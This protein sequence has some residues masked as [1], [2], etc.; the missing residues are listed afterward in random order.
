MLLTS[1]GQSVNQFPFS[2]L[3]IAE[4]DSDLCLGLFEEKLGF[5]SLG[6]RFTCLEK[7]RSKCIYCPRNIVTSIRYVCTVQKALFLNGIGGR[8]FREL[9]T[10]DVAIC[11]VVSTKH[12]YLYA[13]AWMIP[14]K[15]PVVGVCRRSSNFLNLVLLGR[16]QSTKDF[17]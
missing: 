6:T 15:L 14:Y 12:Y 2:V 9:K 17:L 16:I 10:L 7:N 5:F 3:V 11:R 1:T 13:F 8:L 4:T